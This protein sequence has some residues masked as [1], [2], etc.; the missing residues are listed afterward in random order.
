MKLELTPLERFRL[1]NLWALPHQDPLMFRE[2]TDEILALATKKLPEFSRWVQISERMPTAADS[3]NGL[4]MWTDEYGWAEAQ[5]YDYNF[6]IKNTWKPVAWY[7][8]SR[9]VPPAPTPEEIEETEFQKWWAIWKNEIETKWFYDS[10]PRQLWKS[11]S[12]YKKS[13]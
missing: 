8:L 12:E 1:F 4:V 3:M 2:M 9:Y 11:I 10:T 6:S 13:K 7:P 5:R